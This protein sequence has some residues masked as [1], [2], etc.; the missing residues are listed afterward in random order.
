MFGGHLSIDTW[1]RRSRLPATTPCTTE[2]PTPPLGMAECPLATDS[3][4]LCR[5]SSGEDVVS[6]SLDAHSKWPEVISMAITSAHKTISVLRELFARLGIPEQL[7]TDNGPQFIS[8]APQFISRA[9]YHPASNGAAE[10]LVHTVKLAI[11]AGQQSGASLEQSLAAFLLQYRNT[12]HATTG[13]TPSL[14]MFSHLLCT[15][16]NLLRPSVVLQVQD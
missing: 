5:S 13:T 9:P 4:R 1:K 2:S 8:R 10:R 14:L 7:V 16:L 3:C 6:S 11:L 12:L 15:R